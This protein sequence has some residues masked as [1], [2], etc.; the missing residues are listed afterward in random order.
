MS[1]VGVHVLSMHMRVCHTSV[2]RCRAHVRVYV[3]TY[4]MSCLCLHVSYCVCIW[5]T[6]VCEFLCLYVWV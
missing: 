3:H 4:N 5:V 2:Q 6:V 1:F